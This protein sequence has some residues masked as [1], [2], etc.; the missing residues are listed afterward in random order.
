MNINTIY[1]YIKT[2][3]LWFDILCMR[4]NLKILHTQKK[5]V[6]LI[7]WLTAWYEM[8]LFLSIVI[9]SWINLEQ[10]IRTCERTCWRW[11][12][13]TRS[14]NTNSRIWWSLR[15]PRSCWRPWHSMYVHVSTA[16]MYTSHK[17]QFMVEVIFHSK[18]YERIELVFLQF[19]LLTYPRGCMMHLQLFLTKLWSEEKHS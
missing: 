4:R 13:S 19:Y 8:L 7:I 5:N 15:R 6:K 2:H 18:S 1:H 9:R 3:F 17:E 10:R 16:L 14:F 12:N 11:Q